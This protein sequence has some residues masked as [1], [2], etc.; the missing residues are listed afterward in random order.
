MTDFKIGDAV[1]YEFRYAGDGR[2]YTC[3][4]AGIDGDWIRD[5]NAG[6]SFSLSF[7]E[8]DVI[9]WEH[10]TAQQLEKQKNKSKKK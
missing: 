7:R 3:M 9:I 2:K 10:K 5:I 1:T 8:A 4:V 6:N